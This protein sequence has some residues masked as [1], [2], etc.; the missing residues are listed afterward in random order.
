[1]NGWRWLLVLAAWL[2]A[3]CGGASGEAATSDP[4]PASPVV[5][6]CTG[7]IPLNATMCAGAESDLTAD[8]P[9]VVTG[10]SCTCTASCAVTPC[11]YI[12]NAGYALGNDGTCVAEMPSPPGFTDNGDG[13]VTVSDRLGR[14]TWLRNANCRD[15]IGGIS[16]ANGPVSWMDAQTWACELAAGACG[17]QDGSTAGAW[18][19]PS[20]IQLI[21]LSADLAVADPFVGVLST[22]YWSSFSTCINIY[23]AVDMLTGAYFDYPAVSLFSVWPV[24][25]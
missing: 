9:R 14:N 8:T 10:T 4:P 1:M 3:A 5:Y 12:C 18:G 25:M 17:L 20:Q 13:T 15:S 7:P 2:V 6:S 24:R 16:L 11:S 22:P 21:Q 23:G 19:L